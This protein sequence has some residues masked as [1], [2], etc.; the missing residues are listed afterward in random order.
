MG[1]KRN[2]GKEGE[3]GIDTRKR[4]KIYMFSIFESSS[5]GKMVLLSFWV[6]SS[7]SFFSFF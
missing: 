4:V 5:Q 1:E 2:V 3:K 6:E 7:G